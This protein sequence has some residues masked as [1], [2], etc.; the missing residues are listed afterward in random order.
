[1]VK[2][3]RAFALKDI[4]IWSYL[5]TRSENECTHVPFVLFLLKADGFW[6]LDLCHIS[7]SMKACFSRLARDAA[8]PD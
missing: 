3:F 4:V 5:G 1:M 7:M 6:F 8:Q 2:M